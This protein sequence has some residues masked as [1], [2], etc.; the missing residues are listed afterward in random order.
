MG[1]LAH[2]ASGIGCEKLLIV[3]PATR[4]SNQ[5]RPDSRSV[6]EARRGRRVCVY[7][8]SEMRSESE[9]EM[10]S[11]RRQKFEGGGGVSEQ[12]HSS[13]R[14]ASQHALFT[15]IMSCD[16]R[17]PGGAVQSHR[18]LLIASNRGRR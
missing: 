7:A 5:H 14:L 17:D 15:C 11:V 4:S 8:V 10:G 3:S 18:A 13:L 2:C 12:R 1:G 16:H 9:E 6:G